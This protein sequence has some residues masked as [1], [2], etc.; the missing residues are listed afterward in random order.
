M[1]HRDEHRNATTKRIRETEAETGAEEAGIE[2]YGGAI[3]W[4]LG[5]KVWPKGTSRLRRHNYVRKILERRDEVAELSRDSVC[6]LP[7]VRTIRQLRLTSVHLVAPS[8]YSG[9]RIRHTCFFPSSRLAGALRCS[10]S[11][12]LAEAESVQN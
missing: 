3:C 5:E 9:D 8:L 6:P 10:P 12:R 11:N 4:P 7:E 2:G 1:M